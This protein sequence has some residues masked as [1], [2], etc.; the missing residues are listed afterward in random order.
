MSS[1]AAP[2]AWVSPARP[3][4]AM[5]LAAAALVGVGVVAE[6]NP[7]TEPAYAPV[8]AALI[9]GALLTARPRPGESL[10]SFLVVPALV[11]YVRFGA[12]A[13][14]AVAYAS[15]VANGVHGIRGSAL[16]ISALLD[17]L[18]FA[19]AYLLAHG[20]SDQPW[21]AATAFVIGFVGLRVGLRS[22]STRAGVLPRVSGRRAEQP[23]V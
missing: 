2:S 16:V 12:A 11:A 5:A 6:A 17:G 8:G 1:L 14:P 10:A 20:F 3:F 9:A 22:L 7:S 15:L 13:L 19:D 21:L 4:Y 23:A 18:A